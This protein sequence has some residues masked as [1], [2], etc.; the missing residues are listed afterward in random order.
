[1]M[2]LQS[3]CYAASLFLALASLLRWKYHRAV[4]GRL[5][6]SLR[7]YVINPSRIPRLEAAC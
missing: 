6:R 5:R 3:A 7:L 1:M 2:P 4:T